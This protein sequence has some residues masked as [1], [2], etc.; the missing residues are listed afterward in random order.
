[1]KNSCGRREVAAVG[2]AEWLFEL[3]AEL[4]FVDVLSKF[5]FIFF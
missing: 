2:E 5:F 1:M 4:D 3:A